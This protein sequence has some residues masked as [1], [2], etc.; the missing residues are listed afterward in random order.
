MIQIVSIMYYPYPYIHIIILLRSTYYCRCNVFQKAKGIA[1]AQKMGPL[2]IGDFVLPPEDNVNISRNLI[3]CSF[4][5]GK[6]T[7]QTYPKHK[8]FGLGDKKI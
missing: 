3:H 2:K 6:Q 1:N 4:G 8:L 5:R 7:Q